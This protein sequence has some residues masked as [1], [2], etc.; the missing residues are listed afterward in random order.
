MF[1]MY[2][3][4]AAISTTPTIRES[5]RPVRGRSTPSQLRNTLPEGAVSA[6]ALNIPAAKLSVGDSV[7]GSGWRRWGRR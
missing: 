5:I 3:R 4:R 6:T 2:S 7:A 1:T